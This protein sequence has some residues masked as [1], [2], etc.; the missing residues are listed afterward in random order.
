MYTN[1][2]RGLADDYC[3]GCNET[4]RYQTEPR[5]GGQS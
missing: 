2:K 4:K 5:Y 1:A 3:A